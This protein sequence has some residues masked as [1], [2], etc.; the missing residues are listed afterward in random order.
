MAILT[1]ALIEVVHEKPCTQIIVPTQIVRIQL[2]LNWKLRK[3]TNNYWSSSENY[4]K[5]I[6]QLEYLVSTIIEAASSRSLDWWSVLYARAYATFSKTSAPFSPNLQ[7]TMRGKIHQNKVMCT[8]CG[9]KRTI[10][11]NIREQH[12]SAICKSRCGLNVP[13]A[14]MYIA[15]PS[16][17]PCAN[18]SWNK[19]I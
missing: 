2:D 9:Y 17:P 10:Q 7:E 8:E 5:L 12:L 13:S 3:R 15:L 4:N 11:L 1:V 19:K 18:G 6:K 16:P 14:S